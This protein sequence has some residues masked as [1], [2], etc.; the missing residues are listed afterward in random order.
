MNYYINFAALELYCNIAW[1]L[2]Q[3]RFL[4][5]CLWNDFS[6]WSECDKDCDGG[7]QHRSR[8]VF[9][10]AQFGG[11]PCE[12]GEFEEQACNENPCASK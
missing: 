7:K 10:E 2:H 3:N 11:E 6:A 12:G 8:I 9:Q 5:N 4:V 1:N